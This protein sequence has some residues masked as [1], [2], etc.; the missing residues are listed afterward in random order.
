MPHERVILVFIS[1]VRN[2]ENNYNTTWEICMYNCWAIVWYQRGIFMSLI[3]IPTHPERLFPVD[4]NKS[5]WPT[6]YNIQPYGHPLPD[7]HQSSP[8]PWLFSWQGLHPIT[9]ATKK[10]H[11]PWWRHRMETYSALLDLCGGNSPV[12]GEFPS[13]R[14]VTRSFDVFSDLGL[15]KH[16]SKQPWR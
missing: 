9:S 13:Q 6:V 3:V 1:R 7:H 8:Q 12:T 4:M 11:P 16:L 14:S 5:V 15:N 10:R 2:N